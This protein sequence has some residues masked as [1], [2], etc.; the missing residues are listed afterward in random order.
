MFQPV[1][2]GITADMLSFTKVYSYAESEEGLRIWELVRHIDTSSPDSD[3]RRLGTL[4]RISMLADSLHEEAAREN[5]LKSQEYLEQQAALYQM[6]L[7]IVAEDGE[8]R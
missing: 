1:Y 5:K 3:S 4:A 2:N 7:A 6:A 8:K